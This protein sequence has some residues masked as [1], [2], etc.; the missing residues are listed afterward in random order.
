[1]RKIT[2]EDEQYELAA[3]LAE[4]YLDFQTLVVI[5]DRTENQERLDE[6][7]IRY[8]DYEFSQFAINWHLRQNKQGDLFE[9]FK[10]NQAALS[11]FLGDHPSLA[12]IQL[13]F[14]GDFGRAAQILF[15]LAH[16]ETEYLSRKK[17]LMYIFLGH[18]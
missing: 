11:Q 8:Q 12:W 14:N 10:G 16:D 13:V 17:V 7:I 15:Q 2:V 3:K 5:C 18:F 1:M 9:R 6:Y 4:K